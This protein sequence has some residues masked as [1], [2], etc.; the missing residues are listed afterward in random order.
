MEVLVELSEEDVKVIKERQM[1]RMQWIQA[2]MD[3]KEAFD[4][5]V[6]KILV[7]AEKVFSLAKKEAKKKQT[8]DK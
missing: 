8:L 4:F 7:A 1:F 2:G 3:E 5:V 6:Q